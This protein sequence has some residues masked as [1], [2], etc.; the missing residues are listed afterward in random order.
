MKNLLFLLLN[1]T[2]IAIYSQSNEM[3]ITY[4]VSIDSS[5]FSKGKDQPN[6]PLKNHYSNVNKLEYDLKIKDNESIFELTDELR[7][8]FEA[9]NLKVATALSSRGIYYYNK[10]NGELIHQKEFTG[11][12]FLVTLNNDVKWSYTN[13]T[14]KI[15]NFNCYKATTIIKFKSGDKMIEKEVTVWYC[16]EIPSSFGPKN[17]NGTPG[18]IL[19]LREA[20]VVFYV[21]KIEKESISR[22]EKPTK[23]ISIKEDE[24]NKIV[25]EKTEE[26]LSQA[27]K[28]INKN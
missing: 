5:F 15:Q 11:N 7:N 21:K 10:L 12:L 4:G 9:N 2:S 27:K 23:G 8:G 14:K 28:H 20:Y 13:E 16:P 17:Y 22:I 24:Y 18:L 1:L 26:F 19:E 25:Q 6:N 3:T